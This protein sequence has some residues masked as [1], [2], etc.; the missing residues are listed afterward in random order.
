ML[1]VELGTV[2][3]FVSAVFYLVGIC[4]FLNKLLLVLGNLFFLSGFYFL[5]GFSETLIFFGRKIRGT[6]CFFIGLVFIVTNVKLLGIPIQIFGVYDFFKTLSPK[7]FEI[8]ADL[9]VVGMLVKYLN[10]NKSSN[11][12]I[13]KKNESIV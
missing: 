2:F 1:K 3:L 13:T 4:Y 12:V 9:P 5:V 8:I 6:L 10:G 11:R 7:V